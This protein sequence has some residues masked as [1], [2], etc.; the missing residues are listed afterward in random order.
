MLQSHTGLRGPEGFGGEQSWGILQ[1]KWIE[2]NFIINLQKIYETLQT[3]YETF[4]TNSHQIYKPLIPKNSSFVKTFQFS[5]R[6]SNLILIETI[7]N[8]GDFI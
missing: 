5:I 6:M 3:I 8:S 1:I 7:F 2:L 4:K